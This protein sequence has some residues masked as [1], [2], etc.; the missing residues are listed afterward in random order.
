VLLRRAVSNLLHNALRYTPSGGV[1]L[2]ARRSA[3]AWWIE[4]WDTGIGMAGAATPGLPDDA[5][6]SAG[7]GHGLGLDVVRDCARR[8]QAGLQWRSRPGRGSCFRVGGF[9]DAE[10]PAAG[11]LPPPSPARLGRLFGSVLVVDDDLG[12]STS[13][14]R[15][16]HDWGLEAPAVPGAAAAEAALAAG[17]RPDVVMCDLR[18]RGGERGYALLQSLLERL[19]EARALVVT[20]ELDHP[21][22][23]QAE[24]DGHLV[25]RKPV[26]P[27]RL[28]AVLA[29]LL[30]AREGPPA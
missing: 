18:L 9:A 15:L 13:L 17:L 10:L 27:A 28:H 1:L 16:L 24:S 26:A 25:L 19:P 21:D 8:M 7:H 30:S 5:G 4:V 3:G 20:G 14:Q 23:L 6:G 22:L 12:V 29:S 2:A 11:P